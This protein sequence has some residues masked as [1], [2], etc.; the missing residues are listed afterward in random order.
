MMVSVR[1]PVKVKVERVTFGLCL[2]CG[3]VRDYA[4]K[5]HYEEYRICEEC[6]RNCPDVFHCK[7][8]GVGV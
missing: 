2:C 5:H 4:R 6:D 7:Y 8:G 1:V 3:R